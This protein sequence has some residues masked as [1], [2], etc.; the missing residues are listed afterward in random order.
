M[1]VGIN[2]GRKEYN[3]DAPFYSTDDFSYHAPVV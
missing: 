1:D 2:T 3:V